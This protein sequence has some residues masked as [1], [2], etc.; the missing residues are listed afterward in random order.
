M[1]FLLLFLA[2][3]KCFSHCS[4]CARTDN[5]CT[6]GL[7][8]NKCISSFNIFQV[9]N[10][11][12]HACIRSSRFPFFVRKQR[13]YFI[14]HAIRLKSPIQLFKHF[15]AQKISCL[16]FCCLIPHPINVLS[17]L[18]YLLSHIQCAVNADIKCFKFAIVQ[19]VFPVQCVHVCASLLV[20]KS[21]YY[22]RLKVNY[23]EYSVS[24]CSVLFHRLQP[25]L[26]LS[27]D[28]Y[29]LIFV[30]V[31]SILTVFLKLIIWYQLKVTDRRIRPLLAEEKN[32]NE[33][34]FN[35]K[36][37]YQKKY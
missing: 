17:C 28:S 18:Q 34:Y 9:S 26:T 20:T 10:Q 31:C 6:P 29:W 7:R 35:P 23:I 36:M 32:Y 16:L 19:S 3:W 25:T 11:Q 33:T 24:S 2:Q 12:F 13:R 14:I 22:C 1:S 15:S 37:S 21:D 27:Y 8:E 5:R 4:S 30:L